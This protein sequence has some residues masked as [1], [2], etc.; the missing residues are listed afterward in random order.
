MLVE[1]VH[2]TLLLSFLC[3][4]RDKHEPNFFSHQWSSCIGHGHGCTF[5]DLVYPICSPRWS[6]KRLWPRGLPCH[7]VYSSLF[8][9]SLPHHCNCTCSAWRYKKRPS[10][11]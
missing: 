6:R 11:L 4:E 8:Y 2:L 9:N 5:A 1:I 7:L 3:S 10:A